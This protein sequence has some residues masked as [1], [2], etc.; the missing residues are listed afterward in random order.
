MK[1]MKLNPSLRYFIYLWFS[2]NKFFSLAILLAYFVHRT[3]TLQYFRV[4]HVF[5]SMPYFGVLV[6]KMLELFGR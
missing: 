3:P 4:V 6:V 2:D 1:Q 5:F